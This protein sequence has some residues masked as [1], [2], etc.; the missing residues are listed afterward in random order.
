MVAGQGPSRAG[1]PPSYEGATRWLREIPRTLARLWPD[2]PWRHHLLARAVGA[3]P[4]SRHREGLREHQQVVR[5]LRP[6]SHDHDGGRS[7]RLARLIAP[8]H[9]SSS[10]APA[11]TSTSSAG[12]GAPDGPSRKAPRCCCCGGG[13]GRSETGVLAADICQIVSR[14][15]P[16][17]RPRRGVTRPVHLEPGAMGRRRCAACATCWGIER[18]SCTAFS[19]GG[20][21]SAVLPRHP[22]HPGKLVLT[23]TA[24]PRADWEPCSPPSS[25][26]AAP[27][28]DLARACWLRPRAR[29]A[30][31]YRSTATRCT[32][33][34]AGDPD[35]DARAMVH[36]A[37]NP[38]LRH[39][40]V[41][42]HGLPRCTLRR[43]LSHLVMAGD[44]DPITPMALSEGDRG[45][46]A[47]D[48]DARASPTAATA[49][50]ATSQTPLHVCAV[51]PRLKRHAAPRRG[52]LRQRGPTALTAASC[53]RLDQV[54][55][56]LDLALDE[57]VAP[58]GRALIATSMP[59]STSGLLL[60]RRRRSARRAATGR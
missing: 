56:L 24:T 20:F 30:P 51:H 40:R 16:R 13:P 2:L 60:P 54:G 49:S 22:D 55:M 5:I 58:L 57:G 35:A 15:P 28:R 27:G 26:S 42:C 36:D 32:T 14:G 18:P 53:R 37:V 11:S 50:C 8:D 23:T 47:A 59:L 46:P 44:G 48:A 10:T 9:A 6:S 19:F 33:R 41:P 52:T 17:Q 31:R 45:A 39:R 12:L 7:E 43:P 1:L 3:R 29:A 38:A 21:V 25:A 4:R 34:A